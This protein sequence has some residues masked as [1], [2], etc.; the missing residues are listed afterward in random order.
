MKSIMVTNYWLQ[1]KQILRN[2]LPTPVIK[3]YKN[4]K[5][6]SFNLYRTYKYNFSTV[7]E[8]HPLTIARNLLSTTKKLLINRKRILFY[9]NFPYLKAAPYQICLLLGYDVTNN[10]E[11]SFDLAIKWQRYATFF[12]DEPI[13]SRLASEN[14]SV[15]NNNC[16][17]V[18]KSYIARV[19]HDVFGYSIAVDPLT[20]D[21][22]CVVK[23]DLNA[24]HDGKIISCPIN[25]IQSG[26]VYQKLIENEVE[27]N[28]VLDFRVP[29]FKQS[30]PFVYR[31]L[32]E[33]LREEQRFYGY[34]SLVSVS[35]AEV[36]KV[37]DEDE[38]GKI[39]RFCQKIGLDYGELDVL[40]DR[41][42]QRIYIVD[43]NNTPT[44]RLLFEPV[45]L[46][47]DKCLL[48]SDDRLLALKKLAETFQKELLDK[49]EK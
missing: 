38:I 25:T 41:N 6:K 2:N 32:K 24:Q 8:Q 48:S 35:I 34:L 42:D 29:V 44:S 27:E 21:G 49:P 18:S 23:S 30:I 39:L 40:R 26:V 19:F 5:Y 33:N 11:Q 16:K 22:K 12:P 47:Q 14:I 10:P 3:F 46:P 13:L 9:P 4:Y 43:A 20:Y 36:S 15:V 31:Y 37:F 28:R 17:D 45:E 1:M 7:T